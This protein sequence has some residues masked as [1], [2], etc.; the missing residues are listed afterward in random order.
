[1]ADQGTGFAFDVQVWGKSIKGMAESVVVT[2]QRGF[3]KVYGDTQAVVVAH[4]K[5]M[6]YTVRVEGMSEE[7]QHL[8]LTE[9][10]QAEHDDMPIIVQAAVTIGIKSG[11]G[12][13]AVFLDEEN[14]G[15]TIVLCFEVKAP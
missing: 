4:T 3:R 9:S 7:L 14:N 8:L 12:A 13:A 10:E 5:N 2:A 1:M 15:C 11:E 6:V